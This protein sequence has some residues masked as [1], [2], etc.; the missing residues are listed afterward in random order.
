MYTN[1]T[2]NAQQNYDGDMH[3]RVNQGTAGD[4]KRRLPH[5][6]KR[7]LPFGQFA[8]T[9]RIVADSGVATVCQD[10]KCPNLSE[11]WSRGT[12]TFMVMGHVCT[13][14]CRFCAVTTAKP[15]PLEADEPKRLAD[16]VRRMKLQHVVITAVARDDL[17]DEGAG[18]LALCVREVRR[19]SPQTTIE[20][21]P[22]DLHAREDCIRTLVEA[23]PDIY[24]HNVETVERLHFSIQPSAN[25][26]RSLEVI[27]I[28]RRLRS[29]MPTKSGLMVGLGETWDELITT[30]RDLHLAGCDILTIGQYLA[31]SSD[32]TPVV[33]YYSP[34][35][36]RRLADAAREIGFRSVSSGPFVRSSYNAA[37][38]AVVTAASIA[39][40]TTSVTS[41][42]VPR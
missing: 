29:D 19:L 35:E 30:F 36:F 10:A 6:L 17:E 26:D 25:Y 18:H 31:P 20:V 23:G 42:V 4:P 14:R 40:P 13:R 22:A 1:L 39:F 34:E 27:R 28:V 32:H 3:L 41:R 16:A 37:E 33:K 12:A 21:L 9:R 8:E 15:Q 38:N 7:P 11:C 5:W 24:N 2:P